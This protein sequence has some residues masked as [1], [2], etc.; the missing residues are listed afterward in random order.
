MLSFV[1]SDLFLKIAG[2]V[3]AVAAVLIMIFP[4]PSLIGQVC[5]LIL[6]AGS[7]LGVYSSTGRAAKPS[8]PSSDTPGVP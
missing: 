3:C 7:A 2:A 5:T 1:H 6:A 4:P 8:P